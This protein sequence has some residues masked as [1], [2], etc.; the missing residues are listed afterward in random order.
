MNSNDLA[1]IGDATSHV[2]H[3]I[4][5]NVTSVELDSTES[6][7]LR[8]QFKKRGRKA[9][10]R[11]HGLATDLGFEAATDARGQTADIDW[12]LGKTTARVVRRASVPVLTTA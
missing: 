10:G 12:L 6:E 5:P 2:L 1:R 11:I 7:E 8:Q 9:I 3:V 4:G